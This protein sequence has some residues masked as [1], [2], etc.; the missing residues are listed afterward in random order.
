MCTE[1]VFIF[2]WYGLLGFHGILNSPWYALCVEL[3]HGITW[4]WIKSSIA[5]FAYRLANNDNDNDKNNEN[6]N[7]RDKEEAD[8]S[9][10]SQGLL[11]AIFYGV[12]AGFGDL[13]GGFVFYNFGASYLFFGAAFTILPLFIVFVGQYIFCMKKYRTP[14]IVDAEY[15]PLMVDI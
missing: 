8:L 11:F 12:G 13:F 10:F 7:K 15:Q 1:C 4:S 5:I 14:L 9:T 3:L 2:S 6:N